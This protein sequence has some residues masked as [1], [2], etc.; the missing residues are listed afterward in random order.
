M[1]GEM[2]FWNFIKN[3]AENGEESIELRISGDIVSDDDAWIYEWYG[4]ECASPNVFKTQLKEYSGKDITVWVDSY[5][6]D[7][8]AAVGI[9]NALKEHKG[10]VT[11]KIDS[12][13]MSAAT[14]VSSSGTETCMSPGG[15]YMIHNPWTV[16]QGDSNSMRHEA[17]VL[18]EVRDAMINIYQAKTGK[19]RKKLCD[20]MDNTTYM[21][22]KTALNEG[23]I[24]KI[25]YTDSS[26]PQNPMMFSQRAILNSASDS[27]KKAIEIYRNKNPIEPKPEEGAPIDLYQKL[28]KIN[29]RRYSI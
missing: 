24:D 25:L 3:Q 20:M 1:T 4:M 21:S 2:A 22:A 9:Y 23:F 27:I 7:V 6:G 17:D 11:T 28:A 29:E 19:S 15:I 8:F 13:A 16:V 12:K 5:G 14:I 18:D 10:K 26:E